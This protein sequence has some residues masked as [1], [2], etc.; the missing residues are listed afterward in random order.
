MELLDRF[1]DR[2]P[3]YAA[4]RN[5]DLPG[6]SFV[7]GL[8]TYI[9]Q[10]LIREREVIGKVLQ[11]YPY[12]TGAKF[13]EEVAWRTY[14]KGYLE[15]RPSIWSDYLQQVRSLPGRMNEL[16]FE[17]WQMATRGRTG[18]EC[19]DHWSDQIR[20]TGW[21]HN[22]AR[23]WFASIWIFTLKLPWELGAAFFMEHLIDGDPASNTLSWRWVAG[24]HTKGKR[25]IARAA[26]IAKYTGGAFSPDEQ[27]NEHPEELPGGKEYPQIPLSRVHALS[28]DAFPSLSESPAGLLV[29]P[30]ELTPELGPLQDSPFG[31][32]CVFNARNLMDATQASPLVREFVDGAIND[33]AQRTASHWS[34]KIVKHDGSV[35][36]HRSQAKPGHVGQ[37]EEPRVHTGIVDEWVPNVVT[38]AQNENLKS[39]W[40]VQPTVVP[41]RD[42]TASLLPALRARN[43]KLYEYRNRW[44]AVHWPHAT[45]GFFKFRKGLRERI[46][47]LLAEFRFQS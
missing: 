19:F 38:W 43:I 18:I 45:G 28:P 17:R 7:S 6:K 46:E 47:G 14:W 33:T 27:L 12:E 9:R 4:Q 5:Y 44:D 29:C 40:M 42:A 1:M 20:S 30:D 39:V 41:W 37:M 32:F 26:N 24:L 10:R 16:D 11:H 3:Q 13:I 36:R 25:Y 31:S 21:L 8:S 23:M 22:H 34:A 2:V 15:L 35:R